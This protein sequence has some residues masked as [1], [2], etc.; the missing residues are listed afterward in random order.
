[1]IVGM[2]QVLGRRVLFDDLDNVGV[3]ELTDF[4]ARGERLL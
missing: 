1:M 4:V 3:T 2:E